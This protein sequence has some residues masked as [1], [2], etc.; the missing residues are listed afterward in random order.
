MKEVITKLIPPTDDSAP[1]V[2]GP[3]LDRF[4]RTILYEQDVKYFRAWLTETESEERIMQLSHME[5]QKLFDYWYDGEE[6]EDED[7]D[8]DFDL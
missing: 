2:T 3:G 7:G 8:E 4:C 6:E 5:A 1:P